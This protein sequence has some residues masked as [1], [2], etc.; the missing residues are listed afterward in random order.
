MWE[1]GQVQIDGEA[2]G[3]FQREPHRTFETLE[4]EWVLEPADVGPFEGG[5]NSLTKSDTHSST[6]LHYQYVKNIVIRHTLLIT[7]GRLK[8]IQAEGKHRFSVL[9]HSKIH[10]SAV[11]LLENK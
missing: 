11:N 10:Q 6:T 3:Y 1:I 5:I 8:T 2:K 4:S 7:I 9:H